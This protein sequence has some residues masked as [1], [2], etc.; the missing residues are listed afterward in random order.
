LAAILPSW[1]AEGGPDAQLSRLGDPSMRARIAYE[2]EQIGSDGCHGCVA[3]WNTIEIGGVRNENLNDAVGNTIA[4]LAADRGE[5]P[6]VVFFDLLIRDNLA[7]TI[8]QHVG[9]EENVRTI[10]QHSSHTGGSDAILVGGKPHPRAWGTFP[11]YLGRYVREL[12]VLELA[13]CIHHLTG[14][15]ARRL[16]LQDRGLIREGYHADLVLFD[17]ETVRDTAT[18]DD[19]RQQADGIPYVLVNGVPV[20][21]DGHRTNAQPGHAIRRVDPRSSTPDRRTEP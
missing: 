16:R 19:P 10:M 17:P 21:D 5:P 7:T 1:T 2:M 15:P 4:V 3:D 9:H 14:R 11:R 18:F 20:I 6:S 13:D 12:G 8:L